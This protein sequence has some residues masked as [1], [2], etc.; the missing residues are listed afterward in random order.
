MSDTELISKAQAYADVFVGKDS[1]KNKIARATRYF[2]VMRTE[3]TEATGLGRKVKFSDLHL[4][5]L[6]KI[7]SYLDYDF[8]LGLYKVANLNQEKF[9]A[10]KMKNKRYGSD[11]SEEEEKKEDEYGSEDDDS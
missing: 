8:F 4:T 3:L 10:R 9:N 2:D 5:T 11:W 6:A 7:F 1:K